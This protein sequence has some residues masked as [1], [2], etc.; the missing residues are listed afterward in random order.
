MARI[1]VH[2]LGSEL[3]TLVGP[4][5]RSAAEARSAE[6]DGALQ[7]KLDVVHQGW[8]AKY[9]DRVHGILDELESSGNQALLTGGSSLHIK[10]LVDGIFEGPAWDE[11][12]RAAFRR[13]AEREGA[14]ALHA[15]LAARLAVPERARRDHD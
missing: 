10:S 5:E 12:F 7:E 4:D 11:A 1:L 8:G 9:V 15:E 2:P 3:D 13:R 6:L 14:P